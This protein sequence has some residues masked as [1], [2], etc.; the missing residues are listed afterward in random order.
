MT[1]SVASVDSPYAELL[2]SHLA[3]RSVDILNDNATKCK[4]SGGH[5]IVLTLI[6]EIQGILQARALPYSEH[7]H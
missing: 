6:Q 1:V 2:G 7:A 3:G 4:K 5:A